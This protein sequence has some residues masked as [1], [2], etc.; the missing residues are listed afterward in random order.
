MSCAVPALPVRF[1]M[2]V[3]RRRKEI[4]SIRRKGLRTK[5]ESKLFD[6]LLL[7]GVTALLSSVQVFAAAYF[8]MILVGVIAD[9]LALDV[10]PISFITSLIII[11]LVETILVIM[12]FS[13]DMREVLQEVLDDNKRID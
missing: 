13:T 4:K 5:G 2:V 1:L 11:G 7:T 12:R 10:S 3:I 8:F 9:N 6:A